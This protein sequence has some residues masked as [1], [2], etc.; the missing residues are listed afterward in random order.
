MTNDVDIQVKLGSLILNNPVMPAS[1]TFD[2]RNTLLNQKQLNSLG[3]II[4]KSIALRERKGNPGS[5]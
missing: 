2:I 3:A 4:T 5:S 1:G